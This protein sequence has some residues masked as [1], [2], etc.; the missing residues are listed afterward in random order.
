QDS[1]ALSNAHERLERRGRA[2]ERA[3]RIACFVR[4][5]A[6]TDEEPARTPRGAPRRFTRRDDGYELLRRER[7]RDFH[8]SR[9]V[10]EPTLAALPGE[11]SVPG[12][13]EHARRKH[14]GVARV[15]APPGP[16]TRSSREARLRF[17]EGRP[18]RRSWRAGD[19]AASGER[20]RN[21]GDA[22]AT[23]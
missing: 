14:S 19:T 13:R 20:R 18:F 3:E 22:E 9:L 6:L 7:R 12:R 5:A 10:D 16:F 21:A 17:H 11:E 15:V 2:N 8:R 1:T 23:G 4:R